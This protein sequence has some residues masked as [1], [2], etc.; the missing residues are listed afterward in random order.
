MMKAF[1][2]KGAVASHESY[3]KGN[4]PSPELQAREEPRCYA[5]LAPAAART[6]GGRTGASRCALKANSNYFLKCVKPDFSL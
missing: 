5:H 3:K 2:N 4:R 1:G 6:A